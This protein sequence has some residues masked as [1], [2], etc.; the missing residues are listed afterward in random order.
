V[1]GGGREVE[2][3][4]VGGGWGVRGGAGWCWVFCRW[5]RVLCER[6]RV[7]WVGGGM[8]GGWAGLGVR[9]S[10]GVGLGAFGVW[11]VA[12]GGAP[13]TNVG[14]GL[15]GGAVGGGGGGGGGRGDVVGRGGVG[16]GKVSHL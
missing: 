16:V 9:A 3:E 5:S 10:A 7:G 11:V 4:E 12:V 6:G 13:K 2:R 14:G 8:L 15:G 1:W